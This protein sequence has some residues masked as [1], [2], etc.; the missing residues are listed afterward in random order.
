VPFTPAARPTGA[1]L[2]QH[3]RISTADTN[4][5]NLKGSAGQIYAIQVSNIHATDKRYL[6]LYN[7]ASAPT[8]GT[9]VPVKTITLF[10]GQDFRLY[11]DVGLPFTTG[12][13]YAITS[14]LADN[15]TGAIGANEVVLNIDYI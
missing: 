15:D 12:I 3:K 6:K 7:K 8:V 14:W 4:G 10:P 2:T 1:G 5:V 13:A 9:D 11:W